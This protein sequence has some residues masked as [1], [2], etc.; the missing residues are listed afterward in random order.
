MTNYATPSSTHQNP[1]YLD[2]LNPPQ[3][4]AVTH[5]NGPILIL[6]GAGSGKTRVLTTRIA[7]LVLHHRIW[8]S[9]ILAVTF[10]NK[11]TKEM[12]ERL[13][14]LLGDSA[15]ELWVAT[16]HS[17]CLRVLRQHAVRL[18]YEKNFVIYDSA[19]SKA[20]MKDVLK[21]LSIDEKKFPPDVFLSYID[22]QKNANQMPED[23]AS[24]MGISLA[25]RPIET[26]PKK[27]RDFEALQLDAYSLY[28]Q[29]LMKSNAMDFGDLLCNALRVLERFPDVLEGYR[30]LL[31]YVLV[32]EFQD[33]NSIQYRFIRLLAEPKRN[34]LVVGDDDQ[35]IYAFRGATITNILNFERDF[36]D[37]EVI[38][39]EQN[40]RS[41]GNILELSHAV[42][43]KNQARKD[44]KLWT[45]ADA[46][47]SVGGFVAADE[48]D[49]AW[50][51]T[52]K[53]MA[54]Q[55]AGKTWK[56]CAIFYRTNAQS[57][58]IEEYLV[59]NSV[60]YRIFGGLKF[61]DRKEV[62]DVIAYLRLIANPS[63]NQAF[64]RVLNTPTRGIGAVTVKQLSDFA[65]SEQ[66]SLWQASVIN[67][68]RNA[69]LNDFVS[70]IESL[71][72][73][74]DT[75]GSGAGIGG[76]IDAILLKTDYENR[77]KSSKDPQ[78]QSRIE[79]LRE[80]R[81]AASGY[82]SSDKLLMEGLEAFLDSVTLMA[83]NDAASSESSDGVQDAVSLMTLHLAK[84]LEFPVAFLTGLEEGLLPHQRSIDEGTVDEERRLCYVGITRAMEQLYLSHAQTRGGRAGFSSGSSHRSPSRFILDMPA[85]L[86]ESEGTEDFFAEPNHFESD[87]DG[88]S[89][90]WQKKPGA[91]PTS[92]LSNNSR[93]HASKSQT[94]Q[95]WSKVVTFNNQSSARTTSNNPLGHLVGNA[96]SLVSKANKITSG[97]DPLQLSSIE[98]GL[99]IVH[100]TFGHGTI[101]SFEANPELPLEKQ[102]L[103]IKFDDIEG[104]RKL[105]AG[106]AGL[107]AVAPSDG[108]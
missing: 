59:R 31:H 4:A 92:S 13:E 15:K 53:I 22:K 19:D 70:L 35:S 7:H 21:Q 101:T 71:T 78:A 69:K 41:T 85:H 39:L 29:L 47:K 14:H 52:R 77:L 99:R 84:G 98:E 45:S 6:A 57:R 1:S 36:E 62:K 24:G 44:K 63:D 81:V 76:I 10:T 17:A 108:E 40:Y 102:K 95:G 82:S 26:N 3:L 34:L 27:D 65:V 97:L 18:G 96:D 37:A 91:W 89:G 48:E 51:I 67:R 83:G 66:V 105:V 74:T 33:T 46:G 43:S 11:A 32:D 90:S 73:N 107:F 16:F 25:T 12:R 20:V 104:E 56:D 103:T 9:R 100:G 72:P 5:H 68:A 23:I 88:Y 60:P 87:F 30:R 28:Q 106:K 93:N 58:I 79:N 54:L 42:I 55:Q 49:E 80:L 8:P 64:L 50:F 86:I 94:S 38:K 61:Y 75:N 2:G